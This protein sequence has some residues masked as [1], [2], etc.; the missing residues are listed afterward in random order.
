M[1]KI[2]LK[3]K[4]KVKLTDYGK[5]VYYK[6]LEELNRKLGSI[7]KLCLPKEDEEG[8]TT[9]QLWVFMETYGQYMNMTTPNVIEPLEIIYQEEENV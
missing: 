7:F 1:V 8:Y 2:N 9:F 6:R 4:I 3:E 5:V